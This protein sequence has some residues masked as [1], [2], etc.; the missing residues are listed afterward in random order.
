MRKKQILLIA[1]TFFIATAGTTL[2]INKKNSED[3][4][5]KATEYTTNFTN[6]D[7]NIAAHRGFSSLE[8]ENTTAAIELAAEKDY[9][10]YIEIDARM[11]NDGKI[12][13]SHNDQINISPLSKTSISNLNYKQI[14]NKKLNYQTVI[15]DESILKSSNINEK[16]LIGKRNLSLTNRTYTIAGLL[17]GINSCQDKKI[18][19]DL[20]FNKDVEEFT[21]EL[22]TELQGIDTTNIIFQ[23]SNLLGILYLQE[24]TD[25]NCLG[26]LD[27][28]EDLQYT[29]LF[30][31]V[32]IRKN[33]I[34]HETIAK[35]LDEEKNVAIWTINTTDELHEVTTELD[36][37]YKDIIYITDYPDI[38][39]TKLSETE[40]QKTK[41][42]P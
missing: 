28:K 4:S 20:K 13:L 5:K 37:L 34:N 14:K 25:Y 10:D 9:V 7:F 35:L 8:V 15:L 21:E 36:D 19:L 40:L 18:L 26:I 42:T 27:K 33:L 30:K 32:G 39:A 22:K 1:T 24:H 38:I 29:S 41:N 3:I 23:S 16:E 17:E 11:T 12:V 6:D 2:K 31:N